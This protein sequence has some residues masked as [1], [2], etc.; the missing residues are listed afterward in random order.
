MHFDHAVHYQIEEGWKQRID[1]LRLLYKLDLDRQ[2]AAL[3]AISLVPVLV[4]VIAETGL[5]PQHRR[6]CYPAREEER[7][8]LL[9]NEIASRAGIFVEVNRHFFRRAW[10]QHWYRVAQNR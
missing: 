6:A 2:V 8:H 3:C 5:R 1:H 10:F 7:K 9:V 4:V